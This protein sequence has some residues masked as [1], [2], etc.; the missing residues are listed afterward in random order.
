[1]SPELLLIY[2]HSGIGEFNPEKSDIFSTGL[3]F[4][5]LSLLLNENR[6]SEMNNFD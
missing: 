6:I 3:S 2:S 5:R 1:M 4:L